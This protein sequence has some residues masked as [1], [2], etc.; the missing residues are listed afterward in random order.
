M[1][2]IADLSIFDQEVH[3]PKKRITLSMKGDPLSKDASRGGDRKQHPNNKAEIIEGTTKGRLLGMAK[4]APAA[5]S[6]WHRKV[7]FRRS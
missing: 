4:N 3:E 2:F 1:I 6:N 7:I 5:D